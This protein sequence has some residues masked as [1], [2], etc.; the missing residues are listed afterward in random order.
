M[1]IPASLLELSQTTVDTI[2][3]TGERL[4]FP[5][6]V[7]QGKFSQIYKGNIYQPHLTPEKAF[8]VAFLV[9]KKDSVKKPIKVE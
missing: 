8:Y 9:S 2:V 3:T 1:K 4:K 5:I 6:W 7:E